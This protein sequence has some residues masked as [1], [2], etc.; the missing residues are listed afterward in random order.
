[1]QKAFEALGDWRRDQRGQARTRAFASDMVPLLDDPACAVFL[2]DRPGD[3]C[4]VSFTGIGHGTGGLDVQRPEFLKAGIEGPRLFVI[5]KTRSWGNHL[6]LAR[7]AGAIAPHAEGRRVATLGNS[8]G[9]FLAVLCSG[10]LGAA[11]CLAFSPQ[12]SV[13]PACVPDETRWA[14]YRAAIRAFRYSNLAGAFAPGCRYDLIFGDDPLERMHADCFPARLSN[15]ALYRIIHG[16]HEIAATLKAAGCLHDAV[17]ASLTG[18][19]LGATLR[20]AG[21]PFEMPEKAFEEDTG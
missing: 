2:D 4:L 16:N 9:G 21:I 11:R 7:I 12:W 15:V 13:D 19:D 14:T 8:M 20:R 18:R 17:A 5:D 10:P 1:M 3:G 6:D